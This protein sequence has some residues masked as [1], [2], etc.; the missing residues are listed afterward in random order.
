MNTAPDL[1]SDFLTCRNIAVAGISHTRDTP[2][3]PIYRKLKKA[4]Y[5]V[6]A[7]NPSGGTFEGDQCYKKLQDV[8]PLPDGVVMVTRPEITSILIDDCI[9]LGI[10]RIW[11]HNM[12]GIPA[13]GV[14][15]GSSISPDGIQRAR[16]AGLSVIGGSCPMQF[17]EPV[18]LFHRCLRWYCD[19]TGKLEVS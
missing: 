19:K 16:E 9:R 8:K 5:N 15:G 1:I 7:I 11:I 2:A 17:I 14:P 13:N 4:G 18:D 3:R 10:R 6:F 12:M